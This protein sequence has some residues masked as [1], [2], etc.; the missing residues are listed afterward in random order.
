MA[1]DDDPKQWKVLLVDD[2]PDNL[3]VAEK[4]LSF[5]GAQVHTARNGEEGL[6]VLERIV[7]T[8]I[9]VDLSMPKMD[10]WEMHRKLRENPTIAHVP[11]IALTA[12]AMG[13]DKDR[14]LAAGF[15]GYIAK[16]FRL[17]TFF[18]DIQQCL[19]HIVETRG[20]R[21]IASEKTS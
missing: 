19:D 20:L 9:L 18:T 8:F 3:G 13:G 1:V 5:K 11:V 12:H 10:G 4:I 17:V 15:D 21:G 6:E 7:P 16:P 2:E 14:V